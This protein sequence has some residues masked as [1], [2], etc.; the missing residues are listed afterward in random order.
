VCFVRW[1]PARNKNNLLHANF[2][3]KHARLTPVFMKSSSNLPFF[4]CWLSGFDQS[5]IFLS[6]S[7]VLVFLNDF[8]HVFPLIA[9][10][11]TDLD[12]GVP[13]FQLLFQR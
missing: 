2:S 11:L 5:G 12:D 10:Y 4:L 7:N 1:N 13:F 9:V 6:S 3:P 8:Q